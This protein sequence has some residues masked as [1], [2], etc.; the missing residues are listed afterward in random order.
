MIYESVADCIGQTP[1]VYLR[2]LFP[3]HELEVIAKLEFLNPGGS[4]K[5]RPARFIV[6]QGLKNGMITPQTHLIESSS[7]NLGIALAM[8]AR[9]YNL[10]FTCVVDPKI[11]P[12]NLRILKQLGAGVEMVT[13]ADDQGGYLK[14]RIQRVQELLHYIPHSQ[15][16]NQYANQ[17]NWQAH[18]SHT[19]EEISTQLDRAP[20]CLVVAVST[21]GTIL[22]LAR[23]LRRDNPN[24]RVIAV[25]AV[26]SVIFGAPAGPREIP[27]I[28]AS[29]VP[30]LLCRDEIDEV[31]YVNDRESIQGCH[32]LVAR[33]GIFAGGSSGSVVAAVQKLLSTFPP[34][35][36]VITIFPDRG[37]RYLDIVYNDEWVSSQ[38]GSYELAFPSWK[39]KN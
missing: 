14:T 28:G 18:Y 1:L 15:W 22:G 25:D 38:L 34:R 5:D 23:R 13:T 19:G 36:R 29:R 9:I 39:R 2:R 17:L 8:I 21:T 30:E 6:E 16:I 35:Y 37:D 12:M 27:G 33:E 4:I 11:S 24:L 31:V 32:D 10:A 20:D 7:G 26:G 3:Y